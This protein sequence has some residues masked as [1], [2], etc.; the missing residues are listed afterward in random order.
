MSWSSGS[1][2]GSVAANSKDGGKDSGL[3]TS[4]PVISGV[5]PGM[6]VTGL[7]RKSRQALEGN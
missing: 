3:Y 7:G 1:Q 4:Y 6:R 2:L 5:W